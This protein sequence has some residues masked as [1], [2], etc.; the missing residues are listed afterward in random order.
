MIAVD[1][2][3]I[4]E[5]ETHDVVALHIRESEFENHL[6]GYETSLYL[7]IGESLCACRECRYESYGECQY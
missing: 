5:V 2:V 4:V 3:E 1:S 6:V 7:N